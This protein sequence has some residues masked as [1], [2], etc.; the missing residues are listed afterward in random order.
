MERIPAVFGVRKSIAVNIILGFFIVYFLLSFLVLGFF[1]DELLRHAYPGQDLI[2]VF[3]GFLL[4][5]LLLDLFMRFML[6]DLPVL[7]IQPYLHLPIKKVQA[8][9]LRTV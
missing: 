3:N 1:I 7:A 8:Y 4:F 6:Q 2:A 5:Y 9:S